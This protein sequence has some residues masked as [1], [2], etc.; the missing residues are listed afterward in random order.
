[1]SKIDLLNE[2]F[3][4][5]RKDKDDVAKALFSTLK[6]E[7]DNALKNNAT[8]SDFTIEK[9]AKK[10]TEN[11]KIVGTPDALREIELLQPFMPIMMGED[12]IKKI[13]QEAV[14]MNPD[15][16]N[17]YKNGNKGGMVGVIMKKVAG[18]ADANLVKEIMDREIV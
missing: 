11:A 7:Y 12:E 2:K 6:G 16:A 9:I 13:I 4:Q 14:S 1:M 3:I 10:M 5:A 8:A 17:S 18:K 15:K